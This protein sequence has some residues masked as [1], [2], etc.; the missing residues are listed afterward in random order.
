MIE[1]CY[2]YLSNSSNE[3]PDTQG[4]RE[5]GFTLKLARDMIRTYN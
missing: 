1:L 3:F 4:T 5:Y 2:E